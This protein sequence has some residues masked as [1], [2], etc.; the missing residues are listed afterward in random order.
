MKKIALIGAFDRDNYG[1][2]LMPIVFEEYMNKFHSDFYSNLTFKYYGLKESNMQYLEGKNTI[3]LSSIDTEINDILA[4]VLVGGAIL[5]C[6]YGDMFIHLQENPKLIK[7]YKILDKCI[8]PLFDL[9]CKNK[10]NGKNIRPWLIN[11]FDDKTIIYNTVGGSLTKRKLFLSKK[12]ILNALNKA[13]YISVRDAKTKYYL[14]CNS[15]ANQLYPDSVVILSKVISDEV[16]IKK[17]EEEKKYQVRKLGK[18]IVIQMNA[19]VGL[20]LVN[21]IKE[22][23]EKLYNKY[24]ISCIL[25]PIGRAPGHEDQL[26]LQQLN[27]Q[28]STPHYMPETNNIFETIYL[29]KSATMYCGTSLHGAITSISYCVPH[30]ALTD[31]IPKLNAF[32]NTWDTTPV[33]NTEPKQLIRTYEKLLMV[34]DLK[35]TMIAKRDELQKLVIENFENINEIIKKS[36]FNEKEKLN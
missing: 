3:P 8:R 1:D 11:Q 30:T 13:S 29:I 35:E 6:R 34:K 18:Y 16:I 25:L 31:K 19:K 22:E 9:Y 24:K 4:L 27:D 21:E 20:N 26:P 28:L 2:I 36:D 10:L 14:D 15:V 33:K 23:I 7:R 12:K 17:V 5:P 32:L